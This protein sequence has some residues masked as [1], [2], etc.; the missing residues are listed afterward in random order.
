MWLKIY[1]LA[2]ITVVVLTILWYRRE[3]RREKSQLNVAKSSTMDR[4]EPHLNITPVEE[5]QEAFMS[6]SVMAD[7]STSV[8]IDV[9]KN[10]APE[11]IRMEIRA[12][13]DQPYMGYEL[14]Q[15]LLA[16]NFRYGEMNVFNRYA[17]DGKQVLFSLSVASSNHSFELST[18][19]GFSCSGL[20]MTMP[21]AGR[22]ARGVFDLMLETAG[23][24][25]EDLGGE[26]LDE[27]QLPVNDESI[28]HWHEKIRVFEERQNRAYEG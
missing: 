17:A 27:Q 15:S 19:G 13:P 5:K 26:L 25:I 18:M 16:A 9:P 10:A 2:V 23:Q 11:T 4:R 14:L 3:L 7:V 20:I 6:P 21:L 28:K 8:M 22:G 24:L 12:Y 1:V